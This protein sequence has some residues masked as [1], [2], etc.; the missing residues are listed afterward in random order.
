MNQ[1]AFIHERLACAYYFA[2]PGLCYG[3]FT[4]RLP[5]FRDLTNVNDAWIGFLLLAF[6]VSSFTGLLLSERIISRFGA[7]KTTGFASLFFTINII[8]ASIALGYWQLWSF[9]LLAGFGF[10]LCDV[11]MN[12]AAVV[13][14]RRH[15]KLCMGFL[16]ASFSLGGLAGAFTASFFASFPLSP[17]INFLCIPGFYVLFWPVAY[18][19]MPPTPPEKKV[20]SEKNFKKYPLF[21]YAC[22]IMCL[23]C[24]VSEGSVGEWGSLLLFSVKSAPQSEAAL[25]FAFFC[26]AMVIG[27]FVADRLRAIFN[28][29]LLVLCGAL[30]GA[31]GMTVVLISPYVWV[32]L[33][34]YSVMGFGFSP[35]VPIFFSRA[36]Q[37][38]GISPAHAIFSV[39]IF[40]YAGLLFFPP[41]LGML[42]EAFGLDKALWLIVGACC[43][44]AAGSVFLIQKKDNVQKCSN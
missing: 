39:S 42:G 22:A 17:F 6:G 34:A 29:F 10:G 1:K 24:F 25:V 8:I 23:L 9:C 11:A 3:I 41:F 2:F 18:A 44:I 27:R 37:I 38:P 40:A 13:L 28:D 31:A 19:G 20:S 36:G 7:K 5:A 21:L 43:L 12:A 30:L 16:H 14:E 26:A 33:I 4:S 32:C 15:N 35:L